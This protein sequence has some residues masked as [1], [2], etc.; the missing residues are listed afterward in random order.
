MVDKFFKIPALIANVVNINRYK[1]DKHF[2]ESLVILR[3]KGS[4]KLK[5]WNP[6]LDQLF[7][8]LG[9]GVGYE[10]EQYYN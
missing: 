4:P 8:L 10:K 1:P 5:V 6:A 7:R 3:V 2:L 9:L